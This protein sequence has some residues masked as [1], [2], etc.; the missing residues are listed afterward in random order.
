M[1]FLLLWWY[2]ITS[3]VACNNWIEPGNQFATKELTLPLDFGLGKI[4]PLPHVHSIPVLHVTV[5]LVSAQ[6]RD[7]ES[8]S[9]SSSHFSQLGQQQIT[10]TRENASPTFNPLL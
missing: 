3:N 5:S 2:F 7:L 1:Q 8:D 10:E 6:Q 4:Q 9:E